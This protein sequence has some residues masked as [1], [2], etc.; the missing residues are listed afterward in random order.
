MRARLAGTRAELTDRNLGIPDGLGRC[1][2]Q[3]GAEMRA[4]FPL[5]H[6]SKMEFNTPSLTGLCFLGVLS[7]GAG[8]GLAYGP[9][10]GESPSLESV[11][12]N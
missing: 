5:Q 8:A 2:A 6:A 12:F 1:L 11:T 3:L 7:Q 9:V 4:A 10:T